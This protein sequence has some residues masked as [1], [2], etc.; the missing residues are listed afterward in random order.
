MA[1]AGK[2]RADPRLRLT[3][4]AHQLANGLVAALE[5]LQDPQSSW[6]AQNPKEAGF[7]AKCRHGQGIHIWKAGYTGLMEVT[8]Q[9][10]DGCPNWQAARAA[11]VRAAPGAR[12]T[13]QLV[14]SDDDAHRVGFRGSPT[15][16][17]DG[18]D[19]WANPDAPVGLACRVFRT[20]RGLAGLPSERQLLDVLRPR[21]AS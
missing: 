16:L 5:Q 15:I 7:G 8:I 10:F 20:E 18:V 17:V 9:Y 11:V 1:E 3:D 6:I 2:V 14:E 19:P 21:E 12:V 4:S 13:L